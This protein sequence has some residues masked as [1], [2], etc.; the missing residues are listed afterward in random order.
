MVFVVRFSFINLLSRHHKHLFSC[1]FFRSFVIVRKVVCNDTFFMFKCLLWL[2]YLSYL[3]LGAQISNSGLRRIYVSVV[4]FKA[5]RRSIARIL[6]SLQDF[7]ED[8]VKWKDLVSDPSPIV[9]LTLS[10]LCSILK[11]IISE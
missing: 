5:T 4:C 10:V 8:Q 7:I 2:K 3:L 6:D 11:H 9:R 1:H